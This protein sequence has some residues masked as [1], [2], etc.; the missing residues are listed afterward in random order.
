LILLIRLIFTKEEWSLRRLATTQARALVPIHWRALAAEDKEHLRQGLLQATL[1]EESL[2][3]NHGFAQVVTAIAKLDLEDQEWPGLFD[4]LFQAATQEGNPVARQA[5]TY[6][7]FTF[8]EAFGNKITHKFGEMLRLFHKTL[9]DRVSMDVRV[10]TMLAL[11]RMAMALD[12]EDDEASMQALQEIVPQMV[13]VLKLAVES[14]K[15]DHSNQ[16]FEVF[17]TLLGCESVLNKHFGITVQLMINF[18]VEKALSEEARTQ[19]LSFLMQCIRYR[20]LKVQGLKLGEEMT[21]KC[22]EIA[23]ELKDTT[24]EDEDVTTP[25]SALGLLDLL[26]SS[27]PPSQVV[28]PLLNA[29]GPYVNSP[30]P[31]RRQGGIMA[32]SM[33]VE[34]A[35]D[36]VA[37]QLHEI[38]PLVLRLLEDPVAKVRRAALD[39]AMRLAEDLAEELGK[40]HSKLIPAL[41]KS[42]DVAILSLEGLQ[43]ERNIE[44]IRASCHAIDSMVGGLSSDVVKQYLGELVP[45]LSQ[46]FLHPSLRIKSAAIGAL[47]A[48]AES[49][50][51]AFLPYFRPTMSSMSAFVRIKDDE[52]ELELRCTAC[53]AMASIAV[54]V[55]P[56]AFRP[57]V[58]ALMEATEEGL[59]LNHPKLKETSYLFW[60]AMVKVYHSDFAPFLNGVLRALFE[61]LE[62]EESELEVDLGENAADLAGQE[63]NIGGQKIK[64]AELPGDEQGR[65]HDMDGLP[66]FERVDVDDDDE[67]WDDLAAVTAVAQEKEIAIEVIGDILTHA[68][69]DYLPYVERTIEVLLPLVQHSYEGVRRAAVGTLFRTYAALWDLQGEQVTKWEPGLP[70]RVQPPDEMARVGDIIMTA[71]LAV[72]QEE[73]DRYVPRRMFLISRSS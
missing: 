30:D 54:A 34:G 4:I 69:R 42:L 72:W 68:T 50:K 20:K 39:G 40:E 5:S 37:T 65:F 14:R 22:L 33:C 21:L 32:L 31:D 10:N 62:A 61:S 15:D 60:S 28:V 63:V 51:E 1:Q 8:L 19:A 25:R 9:H 23:T 35:P 13:M 18:A 52:E 55:G 24:L 70:L 11:S 6:L 59:H 64:V 43:D 12:I 66:D 71:T 2:A 45:R 7:F 27:L 38:L 3:L 49:A 29:L 17:Q 44:I 73:E 58:Q 26:A 53:D 36:F 41:V 46:L 57:Y 48:V 56:E 47:G 16:S 67:D